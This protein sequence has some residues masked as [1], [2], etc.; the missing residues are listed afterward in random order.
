MGLPPPILRGAMSNALQETRFWSKPVISQREWSEVYNLRKAIYREAGKVAEEATYRSPLDPVGEAFLV[1]WGTEVIGTF[2]VCNLSQGENARLA[3]G[4]VSG[5]APTRTEKSL[6][7]YF[8]GIHAQNRSAA[9]LVFVFGEVFKYLVRNRLESIYVL[10]DSRLARRYRW[11]GLKPTNRHAVSVFPKSGRLALLR[12]KQVRGGIYGLH[13][14]PVRWNWY[15]RAPTAELLRERA[16][17]AAGM[18]RLVYL[19]YL[20]FAPPAWALKKIA[21]LYLR[22]GKP[23]QNSGRP[24]R[25]FSL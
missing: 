12:T 7:V 25:A 21:A 17:P 14:D 18:H 8:L 2:S 9:A 1:G 19:I 10:A 6:Y 4:K 11:I 3:L 22:L 24:A 23:A 5:S 13:A 16:L 20:A 15:L